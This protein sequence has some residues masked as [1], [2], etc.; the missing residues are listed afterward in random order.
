MI[1]SRGTNPNL[2]EAASG[3]EEMSSQPVDPD[4]QGGFRQLDNWFEADSIKAIF[5]IYVDDFIGFACCQEVNGCPMKRVCAEWKASEPFSLKENGP[6]LFFVCI[7][8]K[9]T[10]SGYVLHQTSYAREVVTK[11]GGDVRPRTTPCDPASFTNP[12]APPSSKVHTD[13]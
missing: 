8:M 2:W 9:R 3:P 1:L 7:K 12:Y 5:G 10:S 11:Y 6:D 4:D 13:A